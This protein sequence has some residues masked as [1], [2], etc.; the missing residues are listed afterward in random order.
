MAENDVAIKCSNY[1]GFSVTGSQEFCQGMYDDHEHQDVPGT[2][3]SDH[4]YEYVFSFYGFII[5][6][7][8]CGAIV[9]IVNKTPF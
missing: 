9:A 2:R 5:A 3:E 8:V 4:W 1:C 7:I 6:L